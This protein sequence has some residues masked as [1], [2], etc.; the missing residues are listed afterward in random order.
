[1]GGFTPTSLGTCPDLTHTFFVSIQETWHLVTTEIRHCR[2]DFCCKS[3][4][5]LKFWIY[6]NRG[7]N[8][9]VWGLNLV[10][11]FQPVGTWNIGGRRAKSGPEFANRKYNR[12]VFLG[13]DLFQFYEGYFYYKYRLCIRVNL[14]IKR[15]ENN[16]LDVNKKTRVCIEFALGNKH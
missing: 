12:N 16:G 1:M 8:G 7:L 15:T 14:E 10:V 6:Q 2:V 13:W 3:D 5:K 11:V 9:V 4:S